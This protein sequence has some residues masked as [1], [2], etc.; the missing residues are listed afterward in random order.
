MGKPLRQGSSPSS[1][2]SMSTSNNTHS[3]VLFSGSATAITSTT[4]ASAKKSKTKLAKGK[5]LIQGMKY[6]IQHYP[7]LKFVWIQAG[8]VASFIKRKCSPLKDKVVT[9]RTFTRAIN[10][11]GHFGGP[12]TMRQYEGENV[13]GVF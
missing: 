13:H 4:V 1:S 7:Q 11:V 6:M 12:E 3:T 9:T 5:E 8:E 10:Y 2:S